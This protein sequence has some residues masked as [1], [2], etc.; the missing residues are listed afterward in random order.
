MPVS[1]FESDIDNKVEAECQTECDIDSIYTLDGFKTYFD[2][3]IAKLR[4]EMEESLKT[5]HTDT[6]LDHP[7]VKRQTAEITFLRA[8]LGRRH[9]EFS[10]REASM[11]TVINILSGEQQIK[12]TRSSQNAR[13]NR[14]TTTGGGSASTWTQPR[15]P[16]PQ[17]TA[18]PPQSFVSSNRFDALPAEE[19]NSEQSPVDQSLNI[20]F[21][22]GNKRSKGQHKKKAAAANSPTNN[23]ER[24]N[25]TQNRDEQSDPDREDTLPGNSSEPET[26]YQAGFR[27]RR[28]EVVVLGDSLLK[29][30]KGHL[31]SR[32]KFRVTNVSISGMKLDELTNMA[33]GLCVRKPQVLFLACGTNSLFPKDS[34]EAMSPADVVAKLREIRDTI[35]GEF[36]TTKV[37]ISSL[38][39]RNDRDGANDKIS[40]VN[41]LLYESGMEFI[42]HPNITL[43]HLNGSKLHLNRSGDIQLSK[44]FVEFCITLW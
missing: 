29:N 33:R 12:S 36:P 16:A 39:V 4:A 24:N 2:T 13:Q 41:S 3:G 43:E 1:H 10:E 18:K 23:G 26:Y 32:R 37:I 17:P 21:R 40:E 11:Q 44:N 7:L 35:Q 6:L 8:E 34:N 20:T 9:Q 14:P 30:L 27:V 25:G 5:L 28:K 22:R 42:D 31:M 38:I 15:R 19:D